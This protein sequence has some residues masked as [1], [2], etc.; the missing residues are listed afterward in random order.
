MT[1]EPDFD[2]LFG[3]Q[4]A[5]ASSAGDDAYAPGVPVVRMAYFR[6]GTEVQ[7]RGRRCTVSHTVLRR[8][9]LR[10]KLREEN[11]D[12]EAS[13]LAVELTSFALTRVH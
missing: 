3:M 6:P 8:G 13:Q 4:A 12:V 5:G 11:E 10:I 1:S 2:H 9:E 7:Y